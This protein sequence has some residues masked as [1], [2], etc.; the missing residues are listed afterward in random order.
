[1][2]SLSTPKVAYEI[3]L[4]SHAD[5]ASIE[6]L[7]QKVF[8]PGMKARAAYALREGVHHE[9]DLSFVAVAQGKIIGSVRLTYIEIGAQK[10]LML[11]PLGVLPEFK[12]CGVGKALMTEAVAAAKRQAKE[13]T[14]GAQL[15]NLILVGDLAYY[16]PFG[17][18]RVPAGS[19][20]MPRPTDPLRILVCGLTGES[21]A[22][23]A[24]RATTC[25]RAS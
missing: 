11:G 1:M 22:V 9:M 5:Q 15:Q 3:K 7:T 13:K 23:P 14:K 6:F 16:Q 8:G 20:V 4:E 10:A 19:I 21:T 12:N 2:T 17:F 18:E 24:G 25:E